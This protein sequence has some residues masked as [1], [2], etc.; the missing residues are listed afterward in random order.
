MYVWQDLAVSRLLYKRIRFKQKTRKRKWQKVKIYMY[1]EIPKYLSIKVQAVNRK[2]KQVK[3]KMTR[4]FR[5]KFETSQTSIQRSSVN[6]NCSPLIENKSLW[7][8]VI[9]ML[10]HFL[11]NNKHF[12]WMFSSEPIQQ[13]SLNSW[14]VCRPIYRNKRV[15]IWRLNFFQ[16]IKRPGFMENAILNT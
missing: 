8:K 2:A 15:S 6:G 4:D 9:F 12:L 13:N 1:V 11:K 10:Y 5:Q 3:R 14:Y 7:L 16:M